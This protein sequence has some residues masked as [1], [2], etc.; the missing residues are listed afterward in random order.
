ME[1]LDAEEVK[2]SW[3]GEP[4]WLCSHSPGLKVVILTEHIRKGDCNSRGLT[5][6]ICLARK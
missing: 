4:D 2:A 1:D 5:A 6:V 3:D